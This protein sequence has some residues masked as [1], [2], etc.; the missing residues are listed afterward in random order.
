MSLRN[1][2]L[3]AL[4]ALCLCICG[5]WIPPRDYGLTAAGQ[6]PLPPEPRWAGPPP[7]V[8]PDAPLPPGTAAGRTQVPDPLPLQEAFLLALRANEQVLVTDLENRYPAMTAA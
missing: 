1:S 8:T 5:C 7:Y 2:P 3:H 4:L 6:R